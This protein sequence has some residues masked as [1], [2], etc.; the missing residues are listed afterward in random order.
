[1]NKDYSLRYTFQTVQLLHAHPTYPLIDVQ[2][3]NKMIK[4]PLLERTL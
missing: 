1:M 2:I 3:I 4:V